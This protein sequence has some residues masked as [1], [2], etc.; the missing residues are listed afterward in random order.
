VVPEEGT[1]NVNSKGS[2]EKLGD[3]CVARKR[4]ATV[5]MIC[6]S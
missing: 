3:A 1:N 6:G 2:K 5:E 4:C